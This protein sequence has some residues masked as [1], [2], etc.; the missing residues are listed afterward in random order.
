MKQSMR[1]LSNNKKVIKNDG[2]TLVE[3]IV[4]LAVFAI[5]GTVLAM[6]FSGSLRF[7]SEENSQVENQESITTLSVMLEN[8]FRKINS[9]SITNSCLTLVQPTATILYCHNTTNKSIS[10]NGKVIATKI[11][12]ATFTINF[13]ELTST[14]ET[15]ADKRGITNKAI[16]HYFL[17]EGNY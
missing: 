10:R 14:V 2:F 8:D 12:S 16:F 3:L 13:N 7:Y 1:P 15:V 9:M 4:A 17:R 11:N 5:L 6:V